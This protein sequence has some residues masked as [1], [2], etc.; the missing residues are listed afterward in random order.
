MENYPIKIICENQSNIDI[1]SFSHFLAS[2]GVSKLSV[3]IENELVYEITFEKENLGKDFYSK[4]KRTHYLI[5]E[6]CF[7]YLF[8]NQ[9]NQDK[10]FQVRPL[11]LKKND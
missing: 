6:S 7:F 8:E 1:D 10:T 2:F 4:M 9:Q 5:F 11:I 3:N